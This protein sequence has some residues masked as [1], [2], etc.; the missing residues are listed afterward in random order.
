MI[1][2]IEG[3]CLDFPNSWYF[4]LVSVD[5]SFYKLL[6]HDTVCLSMS[7]FYKISGWVEPVLD[8]FVS[9]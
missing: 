5:S 1:C 3:V 4:S 9:G 2:L 8:I 7:V 6:C